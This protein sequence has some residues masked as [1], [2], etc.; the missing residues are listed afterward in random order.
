MISGQKKL[1]MQTG[2]AEESSAYDIVGV[3]KDFHIHSLHQRVLP[4]AYLY[5]S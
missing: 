4:L 2:T 3:V 5:A 1:I